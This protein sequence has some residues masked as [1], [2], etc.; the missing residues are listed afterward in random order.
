VGAVGLGWR[1]DKS[2]EDQL[3]HWH[4]GGTGGYVSFIGFDKNG[5][6]GVVLLSNYGDAW[7]GDDSIDKMGMQILK[8]GS[9]ISFD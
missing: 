7:R 3:I 1:I 4:N 2:I 6:V 5:R 9:K 8:R